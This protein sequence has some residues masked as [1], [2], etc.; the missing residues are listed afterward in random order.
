MVPRPDDVM[1][2]VGVAV[3][4]ATDPAAPPSLDDLRTFAAEHLARHK[5]PEDLAVVDALPLTAMEKVDKRA[6]S[7]NLGF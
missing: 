5:L 4:V 2:E 7:A 1:G 3:V 6:L